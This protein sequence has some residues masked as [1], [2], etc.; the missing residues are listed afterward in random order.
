MKRWGLLLVLLGIGACGGEPDTAVTAGAQADP[1]PV[2]A[3]EPAAD[4]MGKWSRSCALCHVTGNASVEDQCLSPPRFN[5][6]VTKYLR[7]L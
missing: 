7:T 4:V 1:A 5:Q 6:L 2:A 3:V